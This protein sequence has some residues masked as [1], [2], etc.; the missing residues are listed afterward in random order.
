MSEPKP[1]SINVRLTD[2]IFEA[3]EKDI[4]EAIGQPE[5][6][7]YERALL[8]GRLKRIRSLYERRKKWQESIRK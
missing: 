8:E 5:I 3:F 4:L 7:S 2:R 6:E 1:E